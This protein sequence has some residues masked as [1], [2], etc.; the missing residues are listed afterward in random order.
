MISR[1]FIAYVKKIGGADTN[2]P[3]QV[4][5]SYDADTDPYA[6]Q[7]I[8]ETDDGDVVWHFGRDLL[9]QGVDSPE[10]VGEGDVKFRYFGPATGMLAMCLRGP[11]GHCDIAL[12]HQK[13]VQ[14]VYDT[15]IVAEQAR[16]EDVESMVDEFLK[17][18]LDGE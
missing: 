18:V 12:P 13:V 14:F 8:F 16:G 11:D 4:T 9:K 15:Q 2:V 6:V 7:A 5:L 17:E 3:V 1:K 10:Q